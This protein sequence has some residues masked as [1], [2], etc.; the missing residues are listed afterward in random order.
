M[1]EPVPWSAA[2]HDGTVVMTFRGR[3]S[4]NAARESVNALIQWLEEEPLHVVWDISE[5]SGYD[6]LA[7]VIWQAEL[8]PRRKR[9]LSLAVR[10][11]SAFVKLGA[12]AIAVALGIP[13]GD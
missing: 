13:L 5:M 2:I 10:G 4:A 8:L 9:V 3:L 6:P 1:G 12:V 7:R 11:G